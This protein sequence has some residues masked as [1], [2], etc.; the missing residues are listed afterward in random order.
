MVLVHAGHLLRAEPVGLAAQASADQPGADGRQG[1]A[2]G[3]GQE[4]DREL[5]VEG[6]ADV[7]DGQAGGHQGD[8][9]AVGVL[10]GDHRLDLL[11]QGSL[12]ALG[13]DLALQR[14]LDG[15]DEPFTDAVGLGMAVADAV[16]VHHHDEVDPG[17][18]A[19][20]L[21]EGLQEHG[22]VGRLQRGLEAQLVREGLG[23]GHRAVA[24]L[25]VDVV[26]RLEHQGQQGPGREQDH[27]RHLEDEYLA[28]DASESVA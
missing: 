13:V 17:G 18:L 22:G 7:L 6:A 5:A 16:G 1:Q 10:D 8:D 14:G 21:G 11:A 28:G 26:P 25:T 24:C 12:D 2:R 9:L 3:D 15:S 20:L 27:D 23:D 19:R 4:D